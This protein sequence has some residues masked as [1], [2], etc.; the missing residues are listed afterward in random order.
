MQKTWRMLYRLL[1]NEIN[2][3]Y[4][5]VARCNS[6]LNRLRNDTQQ[7]GS[8]VFVCCTHQSITIAFVLRSF[9]TA[10]ATSHNN[11]CNEIRVRRKDKKMCAEGKRGRLK[12]NP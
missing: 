11:P 1:A 8:N 4:L 3:E 9:A 6:N 12:F 5:C 2:D 7:K 10:R